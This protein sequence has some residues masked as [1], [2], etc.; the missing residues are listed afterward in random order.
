MPLSVIIPIQALKA[1]KQLKEQWSNGW[2]KGEE[3]E[4]KKSFNNL[5]SQEDDATEGKEVAAGHPFLS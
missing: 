5:R 1:K 3:E 2:L 4:R